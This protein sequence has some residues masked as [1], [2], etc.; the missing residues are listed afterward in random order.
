M[1]TPAENKKLIVALLSCAATLA[2]VAVLLVVQNSDLLLYS[3]DVPLRAFRERP[4]YAPTH[5][6]YLH[7]EALFLLQYD[8]VRFQRNF[9]IPV[10]L[11]FKVCDDLDPLIGHIPHSNGRPRINIIIQ[12]LVFLQLL[13]GTFFLRTLQGMFNVSE[14][15]IVNIRR[16]FSQALIVTYK[17]TVYGGQFGFS[18]EFLDGISTAAILGINAVAWLDGALFGASISHME[19]QTLKGFIII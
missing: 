6:D 7:R 10:T 9:R 16:R 12:H 15:G 4:A 3:A 13:S 5:N 8:H 19:N 1:P 11:F 2:A 18:R 14:G 17:D